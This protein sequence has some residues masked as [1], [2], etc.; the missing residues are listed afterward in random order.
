M[1]RRRFLLTSVAGALAPPLPSL[2]QETKVWRIGF[3]YFGSLQSS[4]DTG[5]YSSFLQGMR[6]LGYIEG[7]NFV[8][9]ARF[10]DGEGAALSPSG[11]P[12]ACGRHQP[13]TG[14]RP[15]DIHQLDQLARISRKLRVLQFDVETLIA[16]ANTRRAARARRRPPC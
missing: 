3:F 14:R 5:R 9:E 12:R 10:A 2:A 13:A 7:K 16:E 1:D 8:V 4:L 11:N 15:V 6:E